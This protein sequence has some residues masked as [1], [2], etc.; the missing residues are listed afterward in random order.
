MY[1]NP[2][3]FKNIETLFRKED[4][5]KV[6]LFNFD[7]ETKFLLTSMYKHY[8]P[9]MHHLGLFEYENN[10][11]LSEELRRGSMIGEIKYN[12]NILNHKHFHEV[13]E[14]GEK[15]NILNIEKLVIKERYR[16]KKFGTLLL[17][18]AEQDALSNFAEKS[19]TTIKLGNIHSKGTEKF[20]W[21]NYYDVFEETNNFIVMK[22]SL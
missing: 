21:N 10:I 5:C 2:R 17:D 4:C 12:F 15:G 19:Q 18:F 20:F 1:R 11:I 14:Y 16:R 13:E 7:N 8:F 22:K 6:K 9:R 3:Y